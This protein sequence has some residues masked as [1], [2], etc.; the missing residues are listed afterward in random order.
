[1]ADTLRQELQALELQR[2]A[3]MTHPCSRK[4][5]HLKLTSVWWLCQ[6]SPVD[7]AVHIRVREENARAQRRGPVTG[8]GSACGTGGVAEVGLEPDADTRA[9]LALRGRRSCPCGQEMLMKSFLILQRQA[10][11]VYKA[12]G[13][14]FLPDEVPF[15]PDSLVAA[16]RQY[17]LLPHFETA[18]PLQ[19][20]LNV[21]LH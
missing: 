7:L 3:R 16:G 14:L 9:A 12:V 8:G 6:P 10:P 19:W 1:M 18:F 17:L 15:V 2:S 13:A 4:V 20:L 5:D 11:N 21:T